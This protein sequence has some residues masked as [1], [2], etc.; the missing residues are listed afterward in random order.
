[1]EENAFSPTAP[2]GASD[3]EH[4]DAVRDLVSA[5]SRVA[6][7]GIEPEPSSAEKWGLV[8]GVQFS[9]ESIFE[10]FGRFPSSDYYQMQQAPPGSDS[11]PKAT[12]VLRRACNVWPQ[13]LHCTLFH[14][15]SSTLTKNDLVGAIREFCSE[16]SAQ[17]EAHAEAAQFVLKK[18]SHSSG[19]KDGDVF[20]AEVSVPKQIAHFSHSL[21]AHL[22]ARNFECRKVPPH[23]TFTK[24][25]YEDD[26]TN[27]KSWTSLFSSISVSPS[28]CPLV[29]AATQVCER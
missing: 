9:I 27:W 4:T 2:S 14:V 7:D 6:L 25:K 12:D 18:L 3:A 21:S 26:D 29:L 20:V 13:L 5:L 8:M 16:Y 11:P 10:L 1:M 19:R 28:D 15:T 23:V 17:G 22:T 24:K